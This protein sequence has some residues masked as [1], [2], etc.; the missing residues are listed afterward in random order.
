[1]AVTPV[2]VMASNSHPSHQ[3][4]Y[5]MAVPRIRLLSSQELPSHPR[6]ATAPR[7][8]SSITPAAIVRKATAFS[9]ASGL[10]PSI[11]PSLINFPKDQTKKS[12]DG[13]TIERL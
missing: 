1:M 6:S 10:Y 12:P 5:G 3:T 4:T 9:P 13:Y 11:T 2:A 7:I 8:Y